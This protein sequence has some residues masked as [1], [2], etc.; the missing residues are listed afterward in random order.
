MKITKKNDITIELNEEEQQ[1]FLKIL[2]RVDSA[3]SHD[4]CPDGY[5]DVEGFETDLARGLKDSPIFREWAVP[6]L[7]GI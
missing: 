7:R 3:L 6:Y 5:Q 1:T 2:S 4:T